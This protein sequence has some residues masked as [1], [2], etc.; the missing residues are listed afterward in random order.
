MKILIVDDDVV[1][2][3]ILEATL[4]HLNHQVV[5]AEN[6]AQA[7]KLC[8]DDYFPV[9]VTDWMMPE[10]TGL[11]L[12][13]V[14]RQTQRDHYTF[15]IILTTLEG[16]QNYLEA[17]EAGADDF[18]RKP[19]DKDQLAA[20]LKVAERILG[21]REHMQKLE[22]LLPIC[23]YCKKIR[24]E[25]NDWSFMETYIEKRS[26]AKFSHSICPDCLKKHWNM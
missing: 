13:R 17:I 12:C 20:R 8:R 16:K 23:S 21:L 15:I 4:H 26:E 10:M 22:G 19:F 24:S 9:V 5:I 11:E 18:I 7:W 6:G 14:I 3:R 25:N 2:R 1:S